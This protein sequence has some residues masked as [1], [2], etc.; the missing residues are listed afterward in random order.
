[1]PA[2]WDRG[3]TTKDAS[4]CAVPG[5]KSQRWFVTTNAICPCVRTAALGRPVVPEVKKNQHGSS[6]STEA[7]GAA[8]P[9]WRSTRVAILA[10]IGW[11]D[12]DHAAHV[13]NRRADGRD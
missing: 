7:V 3:A 11:L 2:P 4:A 10:E 5:I 9:A 12:R 13:R 6:Y 8:W 1:M